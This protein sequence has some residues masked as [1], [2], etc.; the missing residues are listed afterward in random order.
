F[1]M[2]DGRMRAGVGNDTWR[3]IERHWGQSLR[4]A[5]AFAD[6]LAALT[7]SPRATLDMSPTITPTAKRPRTSC[8][9]RK[10]GRRPARMPGRFRATAMIA[11]Y[12]LEIDTMSH[13]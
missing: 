12:S 4:E 6:Y 7:A 10:D 2:A 11:F 9:L 3:P 13:T 1:A 5:E 8:T